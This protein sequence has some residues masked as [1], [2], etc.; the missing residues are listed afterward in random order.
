MLKRCSPTAPP[1]LHE[2]GRTFG[3]YYC[4]LPRQQDGL[5]L[6][7]Y[8]LTESENKPKAPVDCGAENEI[9]ARDAIRC[10][11]CGYRIMYKKRTKR[12]KIRSLYWNKGLTSF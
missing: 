1:P 3:C 4:L 5:H 7:R 8:H 2:N 10:R 6:W 12:S 9:K 11:D